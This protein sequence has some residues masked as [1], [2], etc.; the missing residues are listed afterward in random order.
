MLEMLGSLHYFLGIKVDRDTSNLYL[1]QTKYTV[2]ILHHCKMVGA[3]PCAIPMASGLKLSQ[4]S[5]DP[6]SN[7]LE[8]FLLVPYNT[9]P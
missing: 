9:I 6:L 2:D 4:Y 3:K 7:P 5:G 8:C 1:S